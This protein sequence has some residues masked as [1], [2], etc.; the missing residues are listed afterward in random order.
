LGAAGREES[1]VVGTDEADELAKPVEDSE[2]LDVP[3][4]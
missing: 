2:P 3:L 4:R 1:R